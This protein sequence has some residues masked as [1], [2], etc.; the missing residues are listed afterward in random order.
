ML[1]PIEVYLVSIAAAVLWGLSPV[2]MKRGLERDGTSMLAAVVLVIVSFGFFTTI[3]TI[4]YGPHDSYLGLSST[5]TVIFLFGGVIGSSLGRLVL[6]VGVDRV[7]A[8]VNTAVVNTRPLFAS[9]LAVAL[10]GEPVS[11]WLGIGIVAI[12]AGVV[13]L[14][15]SR[16]GDI[17]GWEPYELAF[18]LFAAIAYGAG[19]VVRRYGFTMTE[20][21]VLSAFV[22]N[23]FA[24]MGILVSY[25]LV[26][27]GPD[28][29]QASRRTYAYFATGGFL[30]SLGLLCTFLAL[31]R[32][33]VVVVDPLVGTAPLFAVLFTYIFLQRVE[34]VTR[35]V[36]LGAVFVLV[37]VVFVTLA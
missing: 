3:A 4:T 6:Y 33:P 17:R 19:N 1:A 36:V 30:S 20:A 14:S 29:F 13:S 11:V 9:I 28:L 21:D 5:G 31:S 32:G 22:L 15:L 7:G 16:G 37:G 24:A 25:A 23:E 12:V 35:G 18:P 26:T 2:V 10:L 27:R 8:S 34:R